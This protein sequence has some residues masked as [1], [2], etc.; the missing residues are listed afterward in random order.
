MPILVGSNGGV[1]APL[2][3][4]PVADGRFERAVLLLDPHSAETAGDLGVGHPRVLSDLTVEI[5][6]IDELQRSPK[7]GAERQ[8]TTGKLL[9]LSLGRQ[10]ND[11]LLAHAT[12]IRKALLDA[13]TRTRSRNHELHLAEAGDLAVRQ[14]GDELI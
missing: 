9:L 5:L 6:A 2:R 8:P 1:D 3:G 13:I 7:Q 11:V 10:P 4:I 12:T 14:I